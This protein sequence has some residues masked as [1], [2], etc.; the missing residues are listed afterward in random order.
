MGFLDGGGASDFLN[1]DS[2]RG[3]EMFG[4]GSGGGGFLSGLQKFMGGKG[5]GNALDL[6][7]L[8]LQGYGLNKSLGLADKQMGILEDQENRASTAQNYQTGNSLSL[9]LQTT[10]P[11][12]P[13]HARIQ[14]AIAEG[15]FE[16]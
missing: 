4:G 1:M 2:I 13:E 12:T 11:G 14:K 5:F 8:A 16:V 15:Q 3:N 7:S 6:G 9:A 10:T